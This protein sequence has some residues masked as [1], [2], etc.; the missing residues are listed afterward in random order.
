[1]ANMNVQDRAQYERPDLTAP[2][3]TL[4]VTNRRPV[5][6][7]MALAVSCWARSSTRSPGASTAGPRARPRRAALT[8]SA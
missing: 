1:M 3:R 4:R 7:Y 2:D 6:A 8:P 5:I